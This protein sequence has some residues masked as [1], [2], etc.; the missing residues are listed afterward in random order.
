MGDRL[1]ESTPEFC[2]CSAMKDDNV[3]EQLHF[4]LHLEANKLCKVAPLLHI[5]VGSNFLNGGSF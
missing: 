3:F 5:Q 4:W 2:V 1:S